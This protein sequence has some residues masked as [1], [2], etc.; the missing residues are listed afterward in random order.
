MCKES[1][2]NVLGLANN[3]H[4]TSLAWMVL[5]LS[6]WSIT[7]IGFFAVWISSDLDNSTSRRLVKPSERF[8]SIVPNAPE[9]KDL[10]A[11]EITYT[12]AMQLSEDRLWMM[13]EHCKRWGEHPI[14]IA[15]HTKRNKMDIMTDVLRMGCSPENIVASVMFEEG[16][17][18]INRLRNLAIRSIQTTHCLY[19]DIDFW[20]SKNLHELL[21]MQTVRGAFIEDNK[22]AIVIPAFQMARK[23]PGC[24]DLYIN[25]IECES[26]MVERMAIDKLTLEKSILSG[27][28]NMFDPTNHKGHQSTGYREWLIKQTN[29]ELRSVDCINSNRY[30]PY[31]VFRFCGDIPPFQ[32]RFTGYGKNKLTWAMHMRRAGYQFKVSH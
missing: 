27:N 4:T 17:Y 11:N 30:E 21:S 6:A 5:F 18:P 14:S 24:D 29:F 12:L 7:S 3:M 15:V 25:H 31:L 32:E 13:E 1:A 9:C 19:V 22:L 2:N 20:P 26:S 16:D 10:E 23:G 8:E 28:V